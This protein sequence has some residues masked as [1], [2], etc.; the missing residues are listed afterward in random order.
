MGG[1]GGNLLKGRT[2]NLE[3][4]RGVRGGGGDLLKGR[5]LNLGLGR[6][7]REGDLLK[8]NESKYRSWK[9]GGGG[10]EIIERPQEVLINS[11]YSPPPQ[12]WLD[13]I[14]FLYLYDC[15][16]QFTCNN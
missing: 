10:L 2:L 1:G 3:L 11:P 16:L 12:T 7:V 5:K 9:G 8:G 14:I 6:G 13:I 15:I 4:G